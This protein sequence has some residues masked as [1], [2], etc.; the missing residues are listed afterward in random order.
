LVKFSLH[1]SET[2]KSVNGN[3]DE[4]TKLPREAAYQTWCNG[5]RTEPHR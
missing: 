1:G 4:E 5:T 3:G 2:L